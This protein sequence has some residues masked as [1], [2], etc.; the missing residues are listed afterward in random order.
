MTRLDMN[1]EK[2]KNI[3]RNLEYSYAWDVY[4]SD[5]IIKKILNTSSKSGSGNPGYPDFINI[6]PDEKIL[7][8]MEIKPTIAK[9]KSADGATQDSKEYAVDGIIWYLERFL[10][11]NISNLAIQEYLMN[12]KFVGIAV[13][14]DP[15]NEY[16]HLISTFTI[17]DQN[18]IE[19]TLITDIKDEVD[20]IRVFE[21]IDEEELVNKVSISSKKINKWLRSVESQKRPV[22]LSALMVCLFKIKG[23]G[24]DN[25][26][27]SEY[28]SNTPQTI[29]NKLEPRVRAVLESESI[30]SEKIA[31]LLAELQFIYHDSDLRTTDILKDILNELRD[32]II[33][34]FERKSNYDIIG[35]FYEDFLKWA[36]IAN[37][38]KGIV[39]TPSH[40]TNLFTEL[41]DLK[42][43]DVILDACCGTGAFLISSMN[44]LVTTI[45]TSGIHNKDETISNVK[46]KQLIGFETSPL[47]YSLAISSMLFRGDGKSQI[48]N[49]DS[50]SKE[51][52]D[53]L[54]RLKQEGVSP[55]VGFINPPYGGKDNK[56]NP[57]K[58]EIQ[59]LTRLLDLCSRYVVMIAPLSTY[60]KDD[61]IRNQILE[62]HT[63]RAVINM[64]KD[65]FVPN[66]STNTA[67]SVFETNIPQGD[68]K[69]VFYD[70]KDDGFILSKSKG[71][72]DIYG[73]WNSIKQETLNKISNPVEN[74]DGISLVYTPIKKG[75]EW[76]IQD[77]S[78]ID[79]STLKPEDFENS[80]KEHLVFK[81]KENMHLLGKDIDEVS[82]LNVLS[83]YY[84]RDEGQNG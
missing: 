19:Q 81:A 48:Y 41:I 39:L 53:I 31:V 16:N 38:K 57:T 10:N 18:V 3:C 68:Q 25:S 22:L 73:K 50:F 34:L 4:P 71:R 43:N 56:D 12:W 40:I 7:V 84:A 79:Y 82:L 52:D 45:Q 80:I 20:Y 44:K 5:D 72:T 60:F 46:R 1:D 30:P 21:N 17:I 61:S 55:T 14:G 33:P 28:N 23:A 47:M 76:L 67:I 78:V 24:A 29:I 58:K 69:A 70:M 51:A 8:L 66:A 63:L 32:V 59:F 64:P 77:H 42:S 26:F 9:H 2:V 13:S 65:L 35:K 36:G 54:K 6:N 83:S 62:K 37:V 75:D 27:V 74:A 15:A 49:V 11:K